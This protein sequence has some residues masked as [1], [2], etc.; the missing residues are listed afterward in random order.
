MIAVVYSGSRHAFWKIAQNKKII[1]ECITQGINPC[2]N[3]QKSILQLLNKKN[4]LVNYAES[5]KK[6]Y[7]FAAGASSQ[8]R[9]K[10]L[11]NSLSAF[12]KFT[13][14]YVDSDVTGASIAACYNKTGTV[15]ILSSG[16]ICAYFDGKKVIPNNF[17]LGYILGDEGSASYLGKMLLKQYLMQKLPQDLLVNFEKNYK[18]DR[19]QIFDKVYR[20]PQTLLFLTSFF[21]FYLD[22]RN[23]PFIQKLV[24]DG[25]DLYLKTYVVSTIE[26][27]PNQE[28]HFIGTV[29]GEFQDRLRLAAEKLN[30][31]IT[32]VTKEPIY[33]LLDYYSN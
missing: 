22:N 26:K 11:T 27:Y 5:I 24:D 29:A 31:S 10:E 2:L 16:S 1:A 17:G 30:I 32:T 25:F 19:T 4:E 33:N 6:M 8:E 21:E 13:K 20:K 12:F 7:F 3:D 9:K 28:L 23:H 18:L 14:I 15:G